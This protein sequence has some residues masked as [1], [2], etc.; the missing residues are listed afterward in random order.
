MHSN[1]VKQV[2]LTLIPVSTIPSL[3][4]YVTAFHW[5]G[6]TRVHTVDRFDQ[7][8]LISDGQAHTHQL[9]IMVGVTGLLYDCNRARDT[10]TL[11]LAVVNSSK[12][13]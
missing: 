9:L 5:N 3:S 6:L 7:S 4:V 12:S 8:S 10:C 2:G 13:Q 11:L 1:K